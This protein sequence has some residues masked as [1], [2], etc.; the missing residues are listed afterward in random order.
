MGLMIFRDDIFTSE[1]VC[2]HV[3]VSVHRISTISTGYLS[4]DAP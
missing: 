3:H 4:M 1:C 2:A